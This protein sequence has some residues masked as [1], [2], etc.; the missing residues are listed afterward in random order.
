MGGQ[1]HAGVGEFT[2]TAFVV[3]VVDAMRFGQLFRSRKIGRHFNEFLGKSD[4][5]HIHILYL[6]VGLQY[7]TGDHTTH[8]P[9]VLVASS[10]IV[11]VH[12]HVVEVAPSGVDIHMVHIALST[13]EEDALGVI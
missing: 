11:K 12:E 7:T 4:G 13:V 3:Q 6:V 1:H 10:H 5:I 2:V 9:G 8:I